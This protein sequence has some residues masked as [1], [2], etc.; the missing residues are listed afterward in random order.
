MRKR[1]S[2]GRKRDENTLITFLRRTQE[3]K[4]AIVDKT[5]LAYSRVKEHRE[6]NYTDEEYFYSLR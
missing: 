2:K 3:G 5:S 1:K 4:Y 6:P